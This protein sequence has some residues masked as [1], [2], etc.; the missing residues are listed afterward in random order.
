MATPSMHKLPDE[1][2]T[3]IM[4]LALPCF[5]SDDHISW[6]ATA[7]NVH[8]YLGTLLF[9]CKLWNALALSTPCLWT[10]AYWGGRNGEHTRT[11]EETAA[12]FT[13]FLYRSKCL[14]IHVMIDYPPPDTYYNRVRD[15][16]HAKEWPGSKRVVKDALLMH[17]HRIQ[18]FYWSYPDLDLWP[19]EAT[20]NLL[21][22]LC[23]VQSLELGGI[24]VRMD[25][26]DYL[27]IVSCP[28]FIL[29]CIPSPVYT[30]SLRKFSLVSSQYQAFQGILSQHP[31]DELILSYCGY[32]GVSP[33]P[34]CASKVQFE[35]FDFRNACNIFAA[36]TVHL[37]AVVRDIFHDFPT[38]GNLV[39]LDISF[40]FTV[41]DNIPVS[42]TLLIAH[43]PALRAFSY[44][45]WVMWQQ[46]RDLF[47][48]LG[49]GM[50]WE[51]SRLAKVAPALELLRFVD[52]FAID[53]VD[54]LEHAPWT[55]PED[56]RVLLERRPHLKVEL[57][58][59]NFPNATPWRVYAPVAQEMPERLKAR[60]TTESDFKRA[61]GPAVW[62]LANAV[63]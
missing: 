50:D 20:W 54:D 24:Q 5:E 2:L 52:I 60:E 8:S 63:W 57:A 16:I 33:L 6:S 58:S 59:V 17:S 47:F 26:L 29:P 41:E 44:R 1:L 46:M 37:S 56:L 21:R 27:R 36:N 53:E 9:V 22:S 40:F 45:G 35:G 3:H 43:T 48:Q 39:T 42:P 4:C 23:L 18:S 10:L 61:T 31:L 51:V 38:F 28:G 11:E 12:W 30:A 49:G 19:H 55:G 15:D 13:T 34:S 14:P 62:D 25:S 32:H 7:S